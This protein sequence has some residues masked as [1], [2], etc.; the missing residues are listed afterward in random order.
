[1]IRLAP[2]A[3]AVAA[4]SAWL[5]LAAC[6]APP[7]PAPPPPEVTVAHPLLREITEWDEFLGRVAAVE[8]VD[9]RSR[10]DGY[11][12][13]I[14]FAEGALVQAG[15]VLFVI[16]RRPFAAEL[17]RARAEQDAAAARLQLARSEEKRAAELVGRKLIAEQEFDNRR[18][19]RA[20][21]E[22][23]LAATGAWV[24]RAALDLEYCRVR[25][26]I[27]GRVGRRLVT[28]GNLV[29]SGEN[30]TL[31]TTIVSL[32]PI[33]VYITGDEQVYLRYLRMAR[34]GTR[35]SAREARVPARMRLAD[36]SGWPHEGYVDFVDNQLDQATGTI[37]G[38][39]RFPNADG[40]LT[41]GLFGQVQVRGAGPYPAVLVPETAIGTDQARRIV[42]VLGAGNVAVA[43]GVTPG[44]R[45]G[46]LRAITAGLDVKDRVL[47]NGQARI[48]PGMVVTPTEITLEAPAD[49]AGVEKLD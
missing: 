28:A 12:E 35:P 37:L 16:D 17:A 8:S 45:V 25:A 20:E 10:V 19:R 46:P 38:R 47:V 11:I 21:A 44:R 29:S 34:E 6:G 9:V 31:L 13:S 49:L 36:E 27:G 7:P 14:E 48:R 26:P 18:Q 42:Y 40:V 23:Q 5:L 4:R 32:D 22:A 43:R 2:L 24:Q 3:R 41:P 15:D 39:A 30:A 33:H 1:M